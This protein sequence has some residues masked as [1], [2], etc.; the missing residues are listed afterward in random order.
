MLRTRDGNTGKKISECRASELKTIGFWVAN[1]SGQQLGS[2]LCRSVA[3]IERL[4]GFTF[5]PD[6][7]AS[8]KEQLAPA[9]W[10]LN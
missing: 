3:E 7:D 1:Q 5:F 8:V 4:T 9:D 6:V 2:Q 10:G